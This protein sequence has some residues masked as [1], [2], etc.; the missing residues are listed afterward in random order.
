[1]HQFWTTYQ[2]IKTIEEQRKF[3]KE[4]FPQPRPYI[5]RFREIAES[6][7]RDAAAVDALIWI[8]RN[9]G[10]DPEVNRAV[11]RMA[12]N[13]AGNKRLG[14]VAPRLVPDLVYSLSPAAETLLRAI[15]AKNP[16]RVAQGQACMALAE[17][18]KRESDLVRAL[19]GDTPQARQ[20]RSNYLKQGADQAAFELV[21]SWN[22][23]D[24]SKRSEAMFGRAAKEY[25]DVSDFLR[26]VDMS[27]QA[28]LWEKPNLGI[29]KPAPD[30]AGEDIDGN[31]FKLG[32][33]KGRVVVLLFWG[34]WCGPSRA[35]YPHVR[36]LVKKMERRPFALLG[37]NGDKDKEKLRRRIKD[38]NINWR[39]WWDGGDQGPIAALYDIPGWPTVYILD[40]HGIIRHKFL[41][42]PDDEAFDIDEAIDE[43]TTTAIR[44][45][46]SATP[47]SK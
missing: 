46:P 11:E 28:K 47:T 29:G 22:P 3:F 5:R 16:D 43:L 6:A 35:M 36:S 24:L 34:D 17:Y 15:A 20:L 31:P 7:P 19:K 32:D 33:Y 1:M 45:A 37:I 8:V 9:G 41:G 42:P 12:T 39:S 30:I 38:E 26:M 40:H 21:R 10:P 13:H 23:D 25:T 14:E 18:L 2:N 44:Q 27:A 4:R